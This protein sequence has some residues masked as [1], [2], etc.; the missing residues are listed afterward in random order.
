MVDLSSNRQRVTTI[1]ESHPTCPRPLQD[2]Q[3][4][5]SQCRKLINEWHCELLRFDINDEYP[6]VLER[7]QGEV[8]FS[9]QAQRDDFFRGI[10]ECR[11]RFAEHLLQ[12][13]GA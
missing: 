6:G 12:Q 9:H 13:W 5:L 1:R 11:C 7:L 4:S 2:L 3:I 10:N 8:S